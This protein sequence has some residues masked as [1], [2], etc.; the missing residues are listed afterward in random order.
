MNKRK[1]ISEIIEFT[2]LEELKSEDRLL[3]Q[4]AMDAACTAYAPYSHFRVGAAVI[5]EN[6]E[7]ITGNNQENAVFPSGICAE[8][9]AL[10][11]AHSKYPEVPVRA[12]AVAAIQNENFTDNPVSLCGTCR[13]V[14]AESENRFKNDIKIIAYGRNKIIMVSSVKELLPLFFELS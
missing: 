14:L 2:D 7:I 9:I 8:Q 5:L 4:K 12:I 6:E 10:S 11:Y 3:T 1:I 13:Q